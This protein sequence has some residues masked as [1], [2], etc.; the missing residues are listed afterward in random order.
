[1]QILIAILALSFL[2]IVHELGH[3]TVA[4]L[5]G[6]KVH[7]FSLFMGPKLL[8]FQRGE[9]TYSIRL[10]PI[11][12]YV[13]ME[14]EEQASEDSRAFN[15]KPIWIRSLVIAA[16]PIANLIIA[17]IIIFILT[18]WTGYDTSIIH[19]AE[20]GNVAYSAGLRS[21]DEVIKFSGKRVFSSSDIALFSYATKGKTVDLLVKRGDTTFPIKLTPEETPANYFMIGISPKVG[22]GKDSNIVN[23]VAD[24]SP[25]SKSGM[26]VGDRIVKLDNIK[27]NEF[28][29]IKKFLINSKGRTIKMTV[30]RGSKE[31]DLSITPI[32]SGQPEQFDFGMDFNWEHG[33]IV[34]SL[35]HSVTSTFTIAR[36]V[37]YSLVWLIERKISF[38]QVSG[39]VGIV[40]FIGKAVVAGPTLGDRIQDLLRITAFLS[41]NVGLFN[42]VPFP[43]LDGSKLLLLGIEKVRRKALPPEREAF[44]SLIGFVLLIMLMLFAT[45]NDILH[46]IGIG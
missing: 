16:G 44:I 46:M 40:N 37:Y 36:T 2:I 4:K 8:S 23:Y 41:I 30:Q 22:Y 28:K 34:T 43:A 1:M 7:E 17:F 24:N 9:T 35:T 5:S 39:P 13:R 18:M 11:G 25:A 29:Q 19:T 33:G 26:K 45:Y 38:K 42:L 15:K 6:V 14:G 27:V 21:G 10:V 31:K 12:G 20:P 3:F 32:P